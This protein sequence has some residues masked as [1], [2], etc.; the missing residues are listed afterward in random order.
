MEVG[1]GTPY[2]KLSYW[3]VILT[4]RSLSPSSSSTAIFFTMIAQDSLQ[5]KNYLEVHR[6]ERWEAW[7]VLFECMKVNVQRILR[8]ELVALLG[9][10]ELIP[11]S[12]TNLSKFHLILFTFM[13]KFDVLNH[14]L[15]YSNL[16]QS[17]TNFNLGFL[18]LFQ[19]ELM[20]D[21]EVSNPLVPKLN[22]IYKPNNF[23]GL[24]YP[25]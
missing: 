17:L 2:S 12:I 24:I 3:P 8:L 13:L 5:Y 4:S 9:C 23:M 10:F 6:V 7:S 21:L 22:G 18:T 1:I 19:K 15:G 25:L 16:I 14:I 20:L 11:L